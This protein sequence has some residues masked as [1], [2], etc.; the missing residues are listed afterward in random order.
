VAS[1]NTKIR[2]K[3]SSKKKST[4]GKANNSKKPSGKLRTGM[5]ILVEDIRQGD[6]IVLS[7]WTKS[8]AAE[9]Q[10][11]QLSEEEIYDLMW[12]GEDRFVNRSVEVKKIT[13]CPSQWR[14][15]AHI[16][17][18]ECYDMRQHVWIVDTREKEE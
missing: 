12:N 6:R 9:A 10:G 18:N 4:R 5:R 1:S 13:E 16:N 3:S 11:R 15:H 8:E 14:T 7:W 17:G 2:Q